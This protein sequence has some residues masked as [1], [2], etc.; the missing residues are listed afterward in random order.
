MRNLQCAR[1]GV[2]TRAR[3]FAAV[4]R[5]VGLKLKTELSDAVQHGRAHSGSD[6]FEGM[7]RTICLASAS[8]AG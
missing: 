4:S 2:E 5:S 6:V 8:T 7:L 1:C 3:G